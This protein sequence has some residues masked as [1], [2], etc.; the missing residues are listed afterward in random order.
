MP[1]IGPLR[2]LIGSSP[3]RPP[4]AAQVG[5]RGR[6]GVAGEGGGGGLTL[7]PATNTFNGATKVAA[8]TARDTYATANP[9]WLTQYD[10]EATFT[11]II[12]WPAIPTNTVYQ[13]RR[14]LAWADV[15]GLVRGPKG[16]G[17]LDGTDGS[18]SVMAF[19]ESATAPAAPTVSQDTSNALTF[20]GTWAVAYPSTPSN[21][22]WAV[23][24]RY[25]VDGT[26][27]TIDAANVA[28]PFQAT[29]SDGPAGT[30]GGGALESVGAFTVTV[31]AAND[32]IFLDMGFDWPTSTRWLAIAFNK[33]AYWIDGDGIYGTNAVTASTVG[34]ASAAATRV[35]IPEPVAG[36]VYLGR[37]AANRALIEF[38]QNGFTAAIEFFQ[39][40]P[41]VSQGG[42]GA[43][44]LAVASRAATSLDVTSSTGTDATVP[45]AT[46]ALAGLESAADKTKLDAVAAGAQ[47]NPYRGSDSR[48][49]VDR[50]WCLFRSGRGLA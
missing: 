8:E 35:Q 45:S 25:T 6:G 36:A 26:A 18:A 23:V 9:A 40:I 39:Y 28:G 49:P 15:T 12:T 43:T 33:R 14:L 13:S 44:N 37:T 41:S 30:P 22:V 46:T 20:S 1:P 29:G 16:D 4:R 7:G 34:T 5:T 19:L 42:G 11:I 48:F 2:R 38:S 17:G 10:E 27:R 32:D 47:V 21:A 50:G 3:D 24:V 31:A